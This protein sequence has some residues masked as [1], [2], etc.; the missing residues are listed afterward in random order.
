MF[1]LLTKPQLTHNPYS[2]EGQLE[3]ITLPEGK[4]R[5]PGDNAQDPDLTTPLAKGGAVTQRRRA[6]AAGR[7]LWSRSEGRVQFG[8][9]GVKGI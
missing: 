9:C 5:N 6:E 2:V 7:G 3:A 1:A 8:A 4:M